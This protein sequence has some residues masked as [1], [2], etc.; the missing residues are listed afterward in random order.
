MASKIL[1]VDDD[2]A[3]CLML[4][5]FLEKN[6]FKCDKA[7]TGRECLTL[8]QNTHYDLVITDLR[9][10]DLTG[11]EVL[12]EIKRSYAEMPVVL[13]TGYGEI[14]TAVQAMKL[15]AFEYVSKPV[16]PDEM[17]LIVGS[18]LGARTQTSKNDATTDEIQYLAGKSS[19]SLQ[20]EKYIELVAPTNM[21]VLIKGESGTGKE[22][23]ARKIHQSSSRKSQP[24]VALDCGALS[25]ELAA[26]ELFGHLKG[27]FTGALNN[28]TG[29]FELANGGTL[30]LDEIGN[31][32]YEVQI[33]LLRALQ[34]KR[35]KK[36][37][38]NT[39]LPVDVRIIAA[40]NEDLR[41]AVTNK[42][43][44]EDLY[45]RLNEFSLEVPSLRERGEDIDLF[46]DYFLVRSNEELGKQVG[47][48][49]PEVRDMFHSYSWPGNI[50]EMKNIIKRAVLLAPGKLIEKKH[51]PPEI[52]HPF[53]EMKPAQHGDLKSQTESQE[54][55]IIL[56]T[57]EKTRY[58]KSKAA[59]LLKIDRKTLYNKMKQ[60]GIDH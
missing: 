55:A 19:V 47:S 44:R 7:N 45:H 6:E 16:N 11:I 33:K 40:S 18:A 46:A 30:F 36:V 1:I 60:Y 43:F 49:S 3:F 34:E 50:R 13:M 8:L 42:G 31:L 29:Q 51:L 2:P 58:N 5:T 27:S 23:V 12:R 39:D 54:R 35:I 56:S 52:A 37:G 48:F 22:Y 24:F 14:R 17:L 4:A 57:L 15:G 20:L 26:S 25:D 21:S 38:G 32:S 28:K 9:L 41:E 53:D 59:E 10:P